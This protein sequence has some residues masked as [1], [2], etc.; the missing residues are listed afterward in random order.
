LAL[1]AEVGKTQVALKT[2][3]RIRDKYS[4]CSVI[5][6]PAI[7]TTISEGAYRDIGRKLRLDGIEDDKADGKSLEGGREDVLACVERI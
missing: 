5:W 3:F 6:V 2:A 4:D 7:N 1:G